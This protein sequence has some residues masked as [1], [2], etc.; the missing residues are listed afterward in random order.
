MVVRSG[1]VGLLLA[2]LAACGGSPPTDALQAASDAIDGA[3]LAS[4]CAPEEYRAAIRL[5]E[6]AQRAN[7]RGDYDRAR[8]LAEQAQQQAERARLQAQA[9]SDDCEALN[10]TVEIDEPEVDP[11]AD[12]EVTDYDLT[13]IYFGYDA[14]SLDARARQTLERHAE[15]IRNTDFRVIV[16]G[17]CDEHGTDAY[18]LALGESR[19]RTVAQYLATLGVDRGRLGTISYGEFR[20]A[21]EY[22]DGQ[23][24][25]A[26]FRVRQ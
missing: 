5:F 1:L 15:Y 8:I 25:R 22:D 26:E 2:M 17:H 10:R 4:D 16:E 11:Y 19:A 21:S 23:N 14:F 9:N 3:Q 7:D 24:R 12:V 13:P 20:R 18:N 6:D